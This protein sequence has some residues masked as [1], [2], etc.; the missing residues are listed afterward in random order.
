MNIL[1]IAV[2]GLLA[3]AIAAAPTQAQEKKEQSAAEKKATPQAERGIPFHGKV[4]ALDKAAKTVTVG[5]RVFL[6]TSETRIRK[7][8][9]PATL[10]DGMVG[11]EVGGTYVKGD[12]GKLTARSLR[13]GPKPEGATKAQSKEA[14]KGQAKKAKKDQ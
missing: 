14:A 2:L 9:K 7:L 12:N 10:D 11:E 4:T 5:E 13:F 1:R 3:G 6:V 8:G